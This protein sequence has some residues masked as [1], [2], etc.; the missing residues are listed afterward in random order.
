MWGYPFPTQL[1]GARKISPGNV[2]KPT[3]ERD[4]RRSLPGRKS[5]GSSALPVRPGR[6]RPGA[7][8]PVHGDVVEDVV[9]GEAAG[10]LPVDKGAGDLVVGVDVVVDHPVARATGESSRA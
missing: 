7:G 1:R 3:R 4:L 6:R 9:P 8:Q 2:V 5:L 10:G